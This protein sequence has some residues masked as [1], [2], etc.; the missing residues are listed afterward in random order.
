[1]ETMA[2][3]SLSDVNKYHNNVITAQRSA[4]TFL[5]TIPP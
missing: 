5:A 4:T 1:M 2:L 3:V